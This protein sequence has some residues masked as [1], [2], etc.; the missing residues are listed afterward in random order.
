MKEQKQLFF[1]DYLMKNYRINY[2]SPFKPLIE[3]K[4][5]N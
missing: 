4:I 3:K 1:Y 2:L 5:L